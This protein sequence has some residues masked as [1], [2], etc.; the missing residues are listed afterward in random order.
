MSWDVVVDEQAPA[1]PPPPVM[2]APRDP[3]SSPD[4]TKN[5]F[6]VS[7][8][9]LPAP[10]AICDR[11][12]A[13]QSGVIAQSLHAA[14]DG[15]ISGSVT[16]TAG[17]PVDPNP[18]W[19]KLSLSQDGCATSSKP[20]FISVG[21]RPPTVEF[22]RSGAP[23]DCGVVNPGQ[24]IARGTIPYA[25]SSFGRLV[26]AEELGRLALG[27]IQALVTVDPTPL[28]D[29]SFAF[30]AIIP[31]L[32]LGKH[33]LYFFQAPP[34]PAN[35]TQAEIDA[36]YRAFA[37]IAATPKSRIAV[38]LP[39]PPLGLPVGAGALT[40]VAGL[41]LGASSCALSPGAGVR[42]PRR[43]REHSRRAARLDDARLRQRRLADR[44]RGRDDGL[45]PADLRTGRRFP[46]GRRL[47]RKLSVARAAGR[48]RERGRRVARAAASGRAVRRG[49][50]RRGRAARLRRGCHHGGRRAAAGRLPARIPARCSRSA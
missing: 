11:G 35:A 48:Y 28:P 8:H 39:P 24:L 14:A 19:H 34:P 18:G 29:G 4:P 12:G 5:V 33:L 23:V 10:V 47:G 49:R 36:H 21:I 31:T 32:P 42:A 41:V 20:A 37:S 9:G 22:P 2:L 25:E 15:T 38:A 30:Q 17:T 26:V 16:L 40:G 46:G 13:G 43:R 50:Q 1:A 27:L 6:A 44:A 45:A 3:T 7:G